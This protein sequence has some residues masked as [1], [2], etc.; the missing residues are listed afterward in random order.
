MCT[1]DKHPNECC[2]GP[3]HSRVDHPPGCDPG[4]GVPR[5]LVRPFLLQLL[6]EGPSHGYELAG[7]LKGF[8]PGSPDLE[9]SILYRVLKSM[10]AEGLATSSLD[11]SGAGPARKVYQLTPGGREALDR[12]ALSLE[13]TAG[14]LDSFRK[15]Y[16]RTRT[17]EHA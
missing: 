11:D 16:E 14:L 5:R 17:G 13:K 1:D 4:Q 6:A 2:C 10:E 3:G 12:W 15:R 7:L 9:P 8:S